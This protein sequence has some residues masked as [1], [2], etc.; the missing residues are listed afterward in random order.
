MYLLFRGHMNVKIAGAPQRKQIQKLIFIFTFFTFS[1]FLGFFIHTVFRNSYFWAM[2]FLF[3][4]ISTTRVRIFFVHFIFGNVLTVEA[5]DGW[6]CC[7][8]WKK[9]LNT[10]YL[11]WWHAAAPGRISG[12]SENLAYFRIFSFLNVYPTMIHGWQ[13][14]REKKYCENHSKSGNWELDS[15]FFFFTY[16]F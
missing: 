16:I 6:T 15:T 10:E 4:R 5:A 11:F 8:V 14:G 3:Q 13:S 1:K 9:N 2:K 12:P 7:E